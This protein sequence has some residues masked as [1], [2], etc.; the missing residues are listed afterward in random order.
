ME[1]IELLKK[2]ECSIEG[3]VRRF[4]ADLLGACEAELSC[5]AKVPPSA[6]LLDQ[7]MRQ[8]SQ[9]FMKIVPLATQRCSDFLRA[10]QHKFLP[11]ERYISALQA[12]VVAERESL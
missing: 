4:G 11:A 5:L 7:A 8:L 9:L 12:A 3:V 6:R 10:H 2:M 1:S